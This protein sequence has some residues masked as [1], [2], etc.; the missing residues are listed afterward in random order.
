MVDMGTGGYVSISILIPIEKV[1][2]FSYPYLYLYPVNAEFL[3]KID[4]NSNNIYER[5]YLSSQTPNDSRV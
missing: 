3:V 1:E 4:T 2:Y 5:I